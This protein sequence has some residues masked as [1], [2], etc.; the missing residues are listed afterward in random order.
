MILIWLGGGPATIDMWD[1]KPEAP[2]EIRGEFGTIATALSGIW[3]GE[4]MVRTAAALDRCALVRSLH[5]NVPDHEPGAQYV[6]TGNKPNASLDHP[7]VGSLAARLLP[8]L[9]GMPTYFSLGEA[10]NV[11]AGFLGAAYE[12]FRVAAGHSRQLHDLDGVVLPQEMTRQ[13]LAARCRYLNLLNDGFVRRHAEVDLMPTL[14]EFQQKAY[15]ILASNRI[16]SAF[17]L[18][19]E[20]NT[21]RNMYGTASV[22]Q[23]SLIARRLIE[24]GARFVTVGTTGWDTHTGNFAALRNL[25][26]PLD[27]A[28]AGLVI[29]LEQ[30]GLLAE[31]LVV[32][33]GEFGRTPLVNQAGGRDHWSR[34]ISFLM[35]G[36][37]LKRGYVHGSSD[38]K[39]IDAN[40][41]D[42]TPDD[43][44]ATLLSLLGFPAEYKLQTT[45][46]RPVAMFQN[47]RPIE[48][49][50]A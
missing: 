14:S 37:G 20:P 17:D 40:D 26:P 32:C 18:S 9:A 48:A 35:A 38:P 3:F 41:R 4:H 44:A 19:T 12:P 47:G 24:A 22:G 31:T 13:Q 10:A 11:G 39:G 36:G 27:Q 1:P 5:H 33:G 43:L 8:S 29:D 46:G 45:S 50:I 25:L 28:F 2:R 34:T 7:S 49:L 30:R 21:I 23:N 42:C 15:E 6:M 16:G